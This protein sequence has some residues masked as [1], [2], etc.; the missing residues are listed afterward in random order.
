M[1]KILCITVVTSSSVRCGF[2][3]S[4][5]LIS[6]NANWGNCS[7]W[8]PILLLLI[9]MNVM[10]NIADVDL[11]RLDFHSGLGKL[12]HFGGTFDSKKSS[13]WNLRSLVQFYRLYQGLVHGQFWRI[14]QL[15]TLTLVELPFSISLT[16][17]VTSKSCS[18]T[19]SFS[20]FS[21]YIVD[22][23]EV[24]YRQTRCWLL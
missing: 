9:S 16:F 7:L 2:N 10:Q 6:T 17:L 13:C 20:I 22:K 14:S 3:H 4:S 24:W 12:I 21:K 23:L 11:N 8:T 1:I 19:R 5:S 18:T 15:K